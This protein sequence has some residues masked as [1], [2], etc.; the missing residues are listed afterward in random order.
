[1]IVDRPLPPVQGT[2]GTGPGLSC[3]IDGPRV[4]LGDGSHYPSARHSLRAA[5]IFVDFSDAPASPA[6]TPQGIADRL[7]PAAQRTLRSL[8]YGRFPLRVTRELR[9]LRMPKPLAAYGLGDATTKYDR[10]DAYLRDALAAA[11]SCDRGCRTIAIASPKLSVVTATNARY[12][13]A[14]PSWLTALRRPTID[15]SATEIGVRRYSMYRAV[16]GRQSW[17][18]SVAKKQPARASRTS[19]IWWPLGPTST[20]RAAKCRV[21]SAATSTTELSGAPD[22]F[23][24]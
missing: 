4:D 23:G 24:P 2:P 6:D 7:V 13:P 19:E 14:S 15:H 18:T 3:G 20:S 11:A 8:S 22:C 16:A 1:M 9:W 5:M 17:R 10:Y 12:A 21:T